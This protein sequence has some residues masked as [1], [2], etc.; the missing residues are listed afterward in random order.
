[1]KASCRNSIVGWDRLVA[2]LSPLF[3]G[4]QIMAGPQRAKQAVFRYPG[5]KLL[6]R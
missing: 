1:M 2:A 3:K 6:P 4:P 5:R